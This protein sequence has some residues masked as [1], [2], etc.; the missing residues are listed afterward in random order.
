MQDLEAIR[1]TE[2]RSGP[3]PAV[4]RFCDICNAFKAIYRYL[5]FTLI[6]TLT[7]KCVLVCNLPS[8]TLRSHN[9]CLLEYDVGR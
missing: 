8:R 1:V 4:V 6:L 5:P 3:L 2:T 9:W 7:R